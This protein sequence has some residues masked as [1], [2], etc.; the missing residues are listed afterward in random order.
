LF[1]EAVNSKARHAD[2]LRPMLERHWH[3]EPDE[4]VRRFAEGATFTPGIEGLQTALEVVVF[5]SGVV[6]VSSSKIVPNEGKRE[7]WQESAL[8]FND[9]DE[10]KDAV[11]LILDRLA[12]EAAQPEH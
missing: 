9:I 4:S 7:I 5:E 2:T 12:R 3:S 11:D 10:A 1:S 6:S 8:M